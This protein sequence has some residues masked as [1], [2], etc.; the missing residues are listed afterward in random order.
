VVG[1]LKGLAAQSEVRIVID[2]L[3][4][5]ATSASNVV[6]DALNAL[7]ELPLL[8]VIVTARPDTRLPDRAGRHALAPPRQRR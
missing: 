8:R 5:L 2:A 6:M 3:D 7:A 1:P 4:R